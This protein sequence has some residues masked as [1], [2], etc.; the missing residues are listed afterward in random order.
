MDSVHHK[1]EGAQTELRRL[2]E[3]LSEVE[4]GR[5]LA[6]F[7]DVAGGERYWESEISDY[8]NERVKL[9]CL[10]S[11]NSSSVAA[12]GA[13]QTEHGVFA[14]IPI[15]KSFRHAERVALLPAERLEADLSRV[16]T[17]R[18][19]CREYAR[20]PITMQQ[21]SSLIHYGCGVTGRT[22]G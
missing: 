5:L 3:G 16:L 15:T 9:R 20:V 2:I 19:S 13:P 22:S 4:S 10:H 7:R 1:P 6:L 11:N 17:H 18:R 14:P 12:P 21:L 8:Y